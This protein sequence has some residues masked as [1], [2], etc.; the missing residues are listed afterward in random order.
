ML[1]KYR[2]ESWQYATDGCKGCLN[3]DPS[4][5]KAANPSHI[6]ENKRFNLHWLSPPRHGMYMTLQK[7]LLDFHKKIKRGHIPCYILS[8]STFLVCPQE[9]KEAT[10]LV[11]LQVPALDLLVLPTGEQVRMVLWNGNSSHRG[12]VA[13]Q[14]ELQLTWGKSFW[15]GLGQLLN[16]IN[17]GLQNNHSLTWRKLFKFKEIKTTFDFM[18][19]IKA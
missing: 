17:V 12:N 16:K 8:S 5:T 15:F 10:Y 3:G 2:N 7:T 13:S 19:I 9:N 18:I 11:I 14:R 6:N 1:L 4:T